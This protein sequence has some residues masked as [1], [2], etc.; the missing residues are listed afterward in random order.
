MIDADLDQ[1]PV[2]VFGWRCDCRRAEMAV[3]APAEHAP[4]NYVSVGLLRDDVTIAVPSPVVDGVEVTVD[5][6]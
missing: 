2:P 5:G 1:D 3:V 6:C 4:E